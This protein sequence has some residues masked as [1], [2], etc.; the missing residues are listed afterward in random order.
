MSA[1]QYMKQSMNFIHGSLRTA[2]EGLTPEQL[3]FVPEGESHSI[4]WVMWHGA[5]VEDL[6][7][8][9]FIRGQQQ[10]WES[11]AWAERTGL[12]V[13]GFGTGQSTEDAKAIHI[14]DLSAFAQYASTVAGH[15]DAL[16][17][18]LSDDELDREVKVGQRTESVGQCITLHLITHLNGHRGEV[19]LIRGMMGFPPVLPNQGG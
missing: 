10:E 7:V 8:Q 6:I 19:N 4:A 15:T 9:Q 18:S 2:G 3:H 5:R 13:K 17:D 16:L 14:D 12:P 11:G 1:T